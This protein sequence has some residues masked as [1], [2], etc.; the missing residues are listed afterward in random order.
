[1]PLVTGYIRIQLLEDVSE[2]FRLPVP[3]HSQE[4]DLGVGG[5]IVRGS[6][7]PSW[8]LLVLC[9]DSEWTSQ[10][11][12][13]IRL[14]AYTIVSQ[15]STHFRVSAHPT[16]LLIPWF[17]C[18]YIVTLYVIRT[19]GFSVQFTSAHSHLLARDIQAH[20]RLLG[21]RF[22]WHVK[23]VGWYT[24]VSQ[25]VCPWVLGLHGPKLWGGRPH[26]VGSSK[27]GAAAYTGHYG[28]SDKALHTS[29]VPV[30]KNAP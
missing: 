8:G 18:T 23:T 21:A 27:M 25:V 7:A 29:T 9:M 22:K 5:V 10:I 16:F 19:N 30:K 2:V 26:G 1:M 6:A 12:R 4:E 3:L 15:K 28:T 20:G 17:V 24:V 14:E 11:A 13:I